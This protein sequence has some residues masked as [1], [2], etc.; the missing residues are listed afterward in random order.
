MLAKAAVVTG[1]RG[2][3]GVPPQTPRGDVG[4]QHDARRPR[5]TLVP[6]SSPSDA[7]RE[8][9]AAT[10]HRRALQ[11][12]GTAGVPMK[13]EVPG[14]ENE[15]T[16]HEV[17]I[18]SGKKV[19]E[20]LLRTACPPRASSSRCAINELL[21]KFVMTQAGVA[22]EQD[23]PVGCQTCGGTWAEFREKGLLGC[24]DCYS[25]FEE[26]L[27]PLLSRAHEGG[28]H[29]VGRVP[30]R[31]GVA[32]GLHREL[33]TLRRELEEAIR[34]EEYERAAAIRD[35]IRRLHGEQGAESEPAQP[36]AAPGAGR[37]RRAHDPR[38]GEEPA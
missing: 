5:A 10:V 17:V 38:T 32:A 7:A 2:F 24:P 21:T 22:P 33:S 6:T 29:H 3:P 31:A 34:A 30:K 28:T 26:Q 25:T 18:K 23:K 16:V 12:R 1:A 9:N 13:C 15:A 4:R 35:R 37:P 19:E 8:L 11:T 14:C 20:A 36:G 27:T